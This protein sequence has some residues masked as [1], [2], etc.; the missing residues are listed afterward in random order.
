MS[1]LIDYKFL[2]MFSFT[3]AHVILWQ[4]WVLADGMLYL[5]HTCLIDQAMLSEK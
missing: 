2:D 5:Q 4:G 1:T 3:R